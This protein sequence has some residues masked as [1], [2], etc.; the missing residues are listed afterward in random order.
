MGSNPFNDVEF[1][2]F[3]PFIRCDT[4]EADKLCG[5]YTNRTAKVKQLCW[6]CCCT[7]NE[8][9][10]IR[11]KFKKKTPKMI[12]NWWRKGHGGAKNA[13]TAEPPCV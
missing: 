12:G 10:N 3:V 1:V 13:L 8:S 2:F 7:T 9:D 4:D 6:Y 11:D 5:A